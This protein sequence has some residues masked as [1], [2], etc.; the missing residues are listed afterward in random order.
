MT[1]GPGPESIESLLRAWSPAARSVD[2][3]AR[4]AEAWDYGR[5]S[6]A[7]SGREHRALVALAGLDPRI[8]ALRWAQLEEYQRRALM[9]ATRQAVD[10]GRACAWVFG[11]G[12]GA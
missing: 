8:A 10:L 3:V 9:V 4:L 11:E 5:K 7:A 12:Q 6:L 1:Q 2:P